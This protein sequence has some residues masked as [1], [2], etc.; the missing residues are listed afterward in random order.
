MLQNYQNWQIK[1][2]VILIY[3]HF[4]LQKRQDFKR[5]CTYIAMDGLAKYCQTNSSNFT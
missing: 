5:L 1:P 2:I 4:K 3:I